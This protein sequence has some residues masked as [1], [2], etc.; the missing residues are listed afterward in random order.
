[1]KKCKTCEEEKGIE[2]FYYNKKLDYYTSNCKTCYKEKTSKYQKDNQVR[3]S[4]LQ[5]KWRR[6]NPDIIKGYKYKKTPE[7][8]KSVQIRKSIKLAIRRALSGKQTRKEI[9]YL[10]ITNTGYI[11]Y[12]ESKFKTGMSWKNYGLNGWHID[13][14]IPESSFDFSD[15]ENYY[16]CFNYKN[17]QPLWCYENIKKSSN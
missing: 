1:M 11:S 9:K 7:K 4:E 3:M 6:N 8:K 5:K 17:T 14:I 15:T 10:G 12:L 16:K 2:N 13:H